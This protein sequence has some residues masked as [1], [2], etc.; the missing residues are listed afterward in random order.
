MRFL[1]TVT[2][3]ALAAWFALGSGSGQ[4][5][6]GE[7]ARIDPADIDRSL[8]RAVL[9]DPP[10]IEVAGFE[11]S[12][13]DC[14]GIFDSKLEIDAEV[15]QHGHI[16]LEHGLNARCYNCHSREDRNYLVLAGDVQVPFADVQEVCAGCHG[17]TYRDWER[18]MHGKATGSWEIGSAERS[19]RG[20]TECH[21]PHHPA[22]QPME[23]LPAPRT[24][25]MRATQRD[26]LHQVHDERNPL[27]RRNHA[28][29]S[30]AHPPADKAEGEHGPHE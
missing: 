21:D 29:A 15:R 27:R 13:Q 30:G 10:L 23:P 8:A 28:P 9:G 19:L 5:P 16:Q 25:R 26:P 14:H 6:A 2:F 3:L 18:G 22:Y 1:I 12:C 17:T 7:R 11:M 4:V 20:C 24:L